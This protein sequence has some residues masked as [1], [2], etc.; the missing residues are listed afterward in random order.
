MNEDLKKTAAGENDI[1]VDGKKLT[2]VDD[3]GDP[4][5][6]SKATGYMDSE[7]NIFSVQEGRTLNNDIEEGLG[8]DAL[9]KK[10]GKAAEKASL[11]GVLTTTA[12]GAGAIDSACT[13]WTMIRVAG[14]A[15][16]YYQQRQLI[17]YG[18]EFVKFAH[19]QRAGDATPEESTFFA[20]KLTSTNSEGKNALNSHGY[21]FAA[22]GDVFSPGNFDAETANLKQGNVTDKDIEK[23][24]VQNETSKYVNGQLVSTSLMAKI[25]GAVT[26][27]NS[28]S[29]SKAD[30][31]CKFTKSWKGQALVFGLAAAGAIAAFF[32]GGLSLSAGAIAQGAVSV[33]IS[34]TFALL[35]PKLIDMAKGEVIKGDEN[36]NETGNAVVSGMGGYNAQTAPA[37]GLRP[38]TQ[39][40]YTAYVKTS[41]EVAAKFA[42]EDR[43]DRSP[44][45][46]SSKNTFLGSVLASIVPFTSKMQTASAA[47]IAIPSLVTSSLASLGSGQKSY[48][49]DDSNQYKQCDD[50]EYKG[51][52]A[53]PFCNLRYASGE[54][55][56]DSDVVLKYMLDTKNIVSEDD[57]TPLPGSEYEDFAAKCLNRQSSIGDKFTSYKDGQSQ[58]DADSEGGYQCVAGRQSKTIE[59]RNNM[60]SAFWI[61]TRAEDGMDNDFVDGASNATSTAAVDFTVASFNMCQEINHPDSCPSI[62]T[63]KEKEINVIRGQ[64]SIGN[65][66]LDIVG[67]QEL[68]QPNQKSMLAALSGYQSY[69]AQVP[70]SNGKA[71][72][73]NTSKFTSDK[74]GLLTGV[75]GNGSSDTR[76]NNSFPWVHLKSTS[77]TSVYVMSV[78]SPNDSYGGPNDRYNNAV[79]IK[80][81]ANSVSSDGSLVVITGDFNNGGQTDGS[82]PSVYCYL[83]SDGAYQ[84]AKDMSASKPADKPCPSNQVPIDHIYA[85]TNISGLTATG[86]NHVDDNGTVSGTDHS[87]A[88][89]TYHIPGS[90]SAQNVS[91]LGGV[92]S[93]YKNPVYSG[94]APDPS[95]IKGDDGLY[96]VYATGGS[97]D[98]PF[99]HLTSTDLVKWKTGGRTLAGAPTWVKNGIHWAPDVAKVGSQYILTFTSGTTSAR[100]IGYAVGTSA[101][102]PFTYK[103]VLVDSG[104]FGSPD[105]LGTIDSHIFVDGTTPYLFFGGGVISVLKINVAGDGTI[106]KDKASRKK[107]ITRDSTGTVE[108]SF[109]HKHGSYYYLYYS[110]GSY[111]SRSGANE[112]STRIARATS[113]MGPYQ[114]TS[115]YKPLITGKD[116]FRAPGHNSVITDGAGND[117]IIYHSLRSGSSNRVLMLDPIKYSADGW[118]TVNDGHPSSGIAGVSI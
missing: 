6:D 42:E 9:A 45:D 75:Q 44:F 34:V 63:K 98:N 81:W 19:K 37:S 114:P 99:I 94:S 89:T 3:N 65:P 79:K 101:A 86:W 73:W 28:G 5:A 39:D 1:P 24:V 78:H 41:N 14:F 35:Q 116:P 48:A 13:A 110:Y 70:A 12:F 21:N 82:H 69:P 36:G 30:S 60:F 76:D 92:P 105:A 111:T 49:A 56:T 113:V 74:S 18:Y 26:Q 117:W 84:H 38:A 57:P 54:L 55:D 22:Y 118:P 66:P 103:G 61:D 32:S 58:S 104:E 40:A 31:V 43:A 96:H 8:R 53:D 20:N 68:S 51:L 4:V 106:T 64:S 87:P 108:G 7:G 47:S 115:P 95:A 52:A 10:I 109:V 83:T 80:A 85:S 71:I 59:H 91:A 16:K 88:Y 62:P 29:V 90:S 2:P 17:R 67:A 33:A 102:G 93:S 46:P 112:Y 97:N 100:K 107:L 50:P 15:A 77:G 23:I 72:L 11:K 27:S 25:A